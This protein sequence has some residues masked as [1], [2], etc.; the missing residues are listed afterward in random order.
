MAQRIARTLPVGKR[1]LIR[2]GGGGS[3]SRISDTCSSTDP[4]G[5]GLAA[6][7]K[8]NK[9]A[10][11]SPV[12][13]PRRPGWSYPPLGRHQAT[14]PSES[15]GRADGTDRSCYQGHS[16]CVGKGLDTAITPAS[17]VRRDVRKMWPAGQNKRS[18]RRPGRGDGLNNVR[19]DGVAGTGNSSARVPEEGGHSGMP[20][21]GEVDSIHSERVSP[22]VAAEAAKDVNEVVMDSPGCGQ[23]GLLPHVAGAALLAIAEVASSAEL[24]GMAFLA[25]TGV[26]SPVDPAGM[27]FPANV[28]E[29]FPTEIAGMALPAE[30]SKKTFPAVAE[31]ESLIV[32][33]VASSTDS[34]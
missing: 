26:V 21:V 33:E 3:A 18:P 32:V 4:D 34:M 27:A 31:A 11:V 29:M 6:P 2:G 7:S 22:K 20:P 14:H 30:F 10:W 19:T 13:N 25:V 17:R 5:G 24:A 15:I 1:G 12:V 28:G 23:G 8:M 16:D 9:P